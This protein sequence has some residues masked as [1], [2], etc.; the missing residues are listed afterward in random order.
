MTYAR[1]HHASYYV[2]DEAEIT[3]LR[4]QLRPL[5]D[6]QNPPPGVTHKET[7]Q[8]GTRR[9]IIYSIP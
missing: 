5:L 3:T 2:I 8:D 6:Q 7:F 4:P 9:T 1:H